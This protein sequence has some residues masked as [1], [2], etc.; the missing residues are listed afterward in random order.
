[1]SSLSREV[2]CTCTRLVRFSKHDRDSAAV[3]SHSRATLT[4]TMVL[5]ALGQDPPHPHYDE[6][7]SCTRLPLILAR[8]WT[9]PSSPSY[10]PYGT[11][12]DVGQSPGCTDIIT[13]RKLSVKVFIPI[14]IRLETGNPCSIPSSWPNPRNQRALHASK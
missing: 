11:R 5:F 3:V 1:M 14:G 13:S 2:S 12:D 4:S 10:L 8:D 7:L 6:R 9:N